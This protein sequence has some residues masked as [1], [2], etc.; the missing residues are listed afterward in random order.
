MGSKKPPCCVQDPARGQSTQGQVQGPV[1][2]G[3]PPAQ[4]AQAGHQGNAWPYE[5]SEVPQ[6]HSQPVSP[7]LGSASSSLCEGDTEVKSSV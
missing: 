5:A 2:T 6:L 3:S 1:L 7:T 4:G